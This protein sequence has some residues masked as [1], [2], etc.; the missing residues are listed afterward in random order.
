VCGHAK[1]RVEVDTKV[2][3][4]G[5]RRNSGRPHAERNLWN[6]ELPI[7][8]E[9]N[10]RISVLAGLSWSLLE[11]IHKLTGHVAC[12]VADAWV[13]PKNCMSEEANRKWPT[14]NRMLT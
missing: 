8:L 7:R 2:T 12:I 13:L 6:L 14:G 9:E 4:N 11:H 3:N 1:T 10:Q 5:G